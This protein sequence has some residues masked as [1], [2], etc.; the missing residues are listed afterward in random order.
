MA[1]GRPRAPTEV[2]KLHG[3]YENCKHG[4]RVDDLFP[5]ISGVAI[6]PPAT[7]TDKA[8]AQWNHFVPVLLNLK[9]LA[10][11][12]LV[13]LESAFILMGEYYDA[14]EE[15]QK[16]RNKKKKTNDD[17]IRRS[18]LN[19]WMTRSIKECNSILCRFGVSPSERAKLIGLTPKEEGE[20]YMDPLEVV[21]GEI[22][23]MGE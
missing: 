15:I 23:E 22:Q 11:Q 18:K 1:K 7:L 17:L 14:L 19:N 4:D 3:T 20:Q 9:V 12:D 6:E 2:L 5:V 21:L 16:I 8:A 13:M 10:V